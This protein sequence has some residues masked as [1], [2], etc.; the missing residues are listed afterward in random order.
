MFNSTH[1]LVGLALARTGFDRRVPHASWIAVI[2]A[3]IPDIDIIA[4]VWGTPA[5]I[6]HHRGITHTI[7]GVPLLA[8][9]LAAIGWKVRGEF[10]W[11]FLLA[12]LGAASHLL[13]DYGNNYGLRPFL[14][15]N[16]AWY[17]GDTLFIID[18]LLDIILGGVILSASLLSHYRRRLALAALALAS[19]YAG[20][21]I[22]LRGISETHLNRFTESLDDVQRKEVLPE[23][24]NPFLWVGIVETE[25][26]LLSVRLNVFTGTQEELARMDKNPATRIVQNAEAAAT[27]Q[28]FRRFAR[29][30]VVRVDE[31]DAA[32]RVLMA[33]FRFY[34]PV[35]GTVFG[36]EILLDKS[37]RLTSERIGFAIR[38]P[39]PENGGIP[40]LRRRASTAD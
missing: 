10:R 1:S 35:A 27:A 29:F 12:L 39:E 4:L 24:L 20:C 26:E 2:A 32:Y 23:W 38:I 3:N 16:N 17:Y 13:L 19:I 15:L 28:V 18:P 5:Y 36:A 6:D 37:L 9:M 34:R 14:P 33:D 40:G 22:Q 21:R 30:P 8:L 11:T 7:V 31:L 25:S